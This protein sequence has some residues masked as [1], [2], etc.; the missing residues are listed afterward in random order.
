VFDAPQQTPHEPYHL[1]LENLAKP[2]LLGFYQ[3]C[4]SDS[5]QRLVDAR[6]H[7]LDYARGMLKIPYPFNSRLPARFG[8]S[9]V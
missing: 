7:A 2:L 9:Q 3:H 6:F 1:L 5:E 8:L 4:L